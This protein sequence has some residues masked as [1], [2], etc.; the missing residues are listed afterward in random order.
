MLQVAF[1]YEG[2]NNFNGAPCTGS[3]AFN[4]FFTTSTLIT[5]GTTNTVSFNTAR[6]QNY[7]PSV[8]IRFRF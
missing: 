7:D 3:G 1:Y 2:Q 5:P 6:T 4:G 8:G